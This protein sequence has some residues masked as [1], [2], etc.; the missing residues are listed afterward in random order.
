MNKVSSQVRYGEVERETRETKVSVVLDLDGGHSRG[1]ETGIGFLDHMLELF[2][3]HGQF[4]LG[5]KADGDRHVDD[6]HTVED[7]GITLGQALRGALKD[8]NNIVRYGDTT[9]PM[10]EALV[11]VAMDISGRGVLVFDCPFQR[12]FLGAM[13][14]ENIREFLRALT[15]HACITLHVRRLAGD[16]DHHV[17]EAMFKGLGRALHQ[18]TRYAERSGPPSTKGKLD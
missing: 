12:E 11:Q 9:T 13:A 8:A 16:N 15:T 3:F 14:T 4:S 18:A 5:V 6:H 2:A 7:V 17:A 10:D 1:V